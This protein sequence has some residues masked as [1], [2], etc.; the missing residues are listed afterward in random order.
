MKPN[1]QMSKMQVQNHSIREFR[2]VLPMTVDEYQIGQL[3]SVAQSSKNETGGGEG[4]EVLV[5]QPFDTENFVPSPKLQANGR[6]YISGQFTHKIYHLAEKAP[7]FVKLM[8]PKGAMKIHEL[9]WNAYPYSRTILTNPD[10]MKEK[11]YIIIESFHASDRGDSQNIL[12]LE[13]RDL[14]HRQVVYID[15]A[16]DKLTSGDYDAESDPCLVGS[17]K[18]KRPPLPNDHTG[19]WM[20]EVNPVMCCYKVVKVWFKWF[21]LQKRMENFILSQERR[22]QGNWSS[23]ELWGQYVVKP[24]L[25]KLF[26][27]F[28]H[29]VILY[30]LNDDWFSTI[31]QFVLSPDPAEHSEKKNQPTCTSYFYFFNF[32]AF[33][34]LTKK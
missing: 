31:P 11:F 15:I 6:Y 14:A 22:F 34:C 17:T 27:A 12:G 23:K 16:N 24:Y 7:G 33:F 19:Q 25:K 10:Y 2:I 13:S 32:E 21:G 1:V 9:S 3:W 30:E 4:V 28:M 5:N 20:Q 26:N 29:Q 18:A 8:V